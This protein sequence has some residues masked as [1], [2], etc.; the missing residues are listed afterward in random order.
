MVHPVGNPPGGKGGRVGFICGSG[1]IGFISISEEL[2]L[3][4][5]TTASKEST[6]IPKTALNRRAVLSL[7]SSEARYFEASFGYWSDSSDQPSP[8]ESRHPRTSFE[9]EPKISGQSSDR[10]VPV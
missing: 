5:R 2:F 6:M 7:E 8:S 1:A 3:R 9:D 4:T 10:F